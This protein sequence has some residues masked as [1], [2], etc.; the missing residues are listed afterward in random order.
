MSDEPEITIDISAFEAF[1][2]NH[3][4]LLVTKGGEV[5]DAC[6]TL[7]EDGVC[8]FEVTPPWDNATRAAIWHGR[9]RCWTLPGLVKSEALSELFNDADTIDLLQRVHDGHEV[10]WDGNNWVGKLDEDAQEASDELE[11]LCADLEGRCWQLY[12]A[13]EYVAACELSDIWPAGTSLKQAARSIRSEAMSEGF[14]A[15][16]QSEVE[17]ALLEK[18][19]ELTEEDE[20]FTPT[21]EQAAALAAE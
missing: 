5:W 8:D 9:T 12:P 15:G 16:S 7:D 20:G 6:L 4:P 11:R 1:D 19:H 17:A 13:E 2:L 14:I 10:V 18:L 3:A 21:A